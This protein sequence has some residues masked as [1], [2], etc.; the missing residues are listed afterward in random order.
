MRVLWSEENYLDHAQHIKGREY[1][2]RDRYDGEYGESLK[3]AEE[4][5]Y[6][7]YKTGKPRKAERTKSCK[8]E[9][10][11]KHGH[12]FGEPAH[13]RD[14]P[15]MCTAVCH[16][17]QAE[18]KAGHDPVREHLEHGARESDRVARRDTEQY[19]AHV[20]DR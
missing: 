9:E 19:Y 8:N 10:H 16:A 1:Y 13:F 11:R 14:Y 5:G 4:N 2:A 15:R 20:R 3:C 6:L 18:E 7:G 17:N 12:V